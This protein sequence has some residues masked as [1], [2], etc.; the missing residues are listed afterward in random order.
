MAAPTSSS[1]VTGSGNTSGNS[2]GTGTN[3]SR[4]GS[5]TGVNSGATGTGASGVINTDGSGTGSK[6]NAEIRSSDE[7]TPVP[8]NGTI[9]DNQKPNDLP[10]RRADEAPPTKLK[11]PKK[12]A[13]PKSKTG[14]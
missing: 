13:E 5:S 6:D 11:T 2:S 8:N 14:Q 12:V 10:E 4:T 3:S 9:M 1:G 7:V